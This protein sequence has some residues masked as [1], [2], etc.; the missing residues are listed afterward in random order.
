MTEQTMHLTSEERAWLDGEKGIAI[1]RAMEIVVTLGRM[2][3]AQHLEPVSSVQVAG[4]SYKNLG[5]AGLD[6]LQE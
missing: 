1:Q 5:Q 2:Y 3:G 6:F 4:V